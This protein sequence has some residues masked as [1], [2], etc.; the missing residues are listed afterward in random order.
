MGS[1]TVPIGIANSKL[2]FLLWKNRDK[3][4]VLSMTSVA[5]MNNVHSNVMFMGLEMVVQNPGVCTPNSW[6]VMGQ[7]SMICPP[8]RKSHI[9]ECDINARK[10]GIA[11]RR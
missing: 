8:M 5:T 10:Y 2:D 9:N 3:S 1:R 4:P 7:K 11:F 6:D